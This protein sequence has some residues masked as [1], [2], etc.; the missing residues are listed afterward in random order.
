[1]KYFVRCMSH[2]HFNSNVRLLFCLIVQKWERYCSGL[3]HSFFYKN[4][5]DVSSLNIPKFE[6]QCSYK[7]CSYKIKVCMWP[8]VNFPLQNTILYSVWLILLTATL[9]QWTVVL[10]ILCGDLLLM[11]IILNYGKIL[12]SQIIQ[13]I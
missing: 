10:A 4:S 9:C 1:M 2:F 8:L 11:E 3:T 13:Y 12:N 5:R 7:L 6:A